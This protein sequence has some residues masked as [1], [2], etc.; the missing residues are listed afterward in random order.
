M[1]LRTIPESEVYLYALTKGFQW[2]DEECPYS[3]GALR[4]VYRDM[5]Y[6]LE[7]ARPGTR[8]ALLRTHEALKPALGELGAARSTPIQECVRCGEPASAL[9]CKSCEMRQ[10]LARPMARA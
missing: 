7:D 4:G 8:H 1:P 3:E 10:Q 9:L 2:H 6:K 5:L